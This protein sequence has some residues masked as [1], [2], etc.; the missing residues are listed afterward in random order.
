ML[1]VV[2][3]SIAAHESSKEAQ[4]C[5]GTN[6]AGATVAP[7]LLLTVVLLIVALLM[8]LCWPCVSF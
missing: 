7:L 2:L 1:T 4:I 3:L 6:D 8:L 5:I